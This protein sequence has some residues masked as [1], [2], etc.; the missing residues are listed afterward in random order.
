MRLIRDHDAQMAGV[1]RGDSPEAWPDLPA[2]PTPLREAAGGE[3]RP[4]CHDSTLGA[5]A[6]RGQ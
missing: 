5:R 2:R 3:G 6:R 1:A 4:L